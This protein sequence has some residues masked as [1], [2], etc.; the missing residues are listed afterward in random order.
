MHVIGYGLLIILISGCA[1]APWEWHDTSAAARISAGHDLA[2]CR[3]Y[4]SSQYRPGIP[5]GDPFLEKEA[6]LSGEDS[7]QKP[8]GGL[9]HT[10]REPFPHARTTHNVVVPYTGYP[11]YLDHYAEYLD[12]LVERCMTARNWRYGPQS[13]KKP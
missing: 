3:S 12:A 5:S 6:S 2:E 8:A 9:W 13:E 10:D 11:G 4:A 1:T 7:G